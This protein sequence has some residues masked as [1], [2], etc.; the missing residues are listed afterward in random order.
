VRS[1][2]DDCANAPG[3]PHDLQEALEGRDVHVDQR[4]SSS[5]SQGRSRC[6]SVDGA[7]GEDPTLSTGDDDDDARERER[8]DEQRASIEP[9]FEDVGLLERPGAV[10][11]GEL[12]AD[13]ASRRFHRPEERK[14]GL[15][16]ARD[17]GTRQWC[18]RRKRR[19]DAPARG[20]GAGGAEEVA[21]RGRSKTRRREQR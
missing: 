16:P 20:L 5:E 12:G 18:R 2:D 1:S 6:E 3:E 13:P 21:R 4:H 17:A 11:A 10:R 15:S 7:R 9:D 8:R 14:V 19:R